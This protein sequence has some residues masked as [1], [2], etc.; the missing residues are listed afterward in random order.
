MKTALIAAG[1]LIATTVTGLPDASAKDLK[2]GLTIGGPDGYIHISGPGP[3]NGRGYGR[4]GH[5]YGK[6][7]QGYKHYRN[8]PS[9]GYR[10]TYPGP[11]YGR[12][13]RRRRHCMNPNEIRHWLRY[14]GWHG[15]RIRKLTSHIA[16]IHSHRHGMR[17]RLKINRCSG[18]MLK[19]KPI[20][21]YGPRGYY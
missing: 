7:Y 5:G 12:H 21:G 17:Y 4:K 20:G 13:D 2:L 8:A 15:F 16:V 19:V 14:Q 3:N 18:E 10:Q 11:F 1:A 6:G 9:Y